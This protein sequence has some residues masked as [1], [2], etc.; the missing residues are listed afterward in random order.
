MCGICGVYNFDKEKVIDGQLLKRMNNIMAH[1]GP[2]DEGYYVNQNVGFGHRRL[3]I[4]DLSHAGHQPMPNEDGSIWIT[5]NGEIYNY[6]ELREELIKKGHQFKSRTDTEV[7]VHLYEE[8][9]EECV[10]RLNGM[11]TFAI[12]DER[13]R[14]LFIARDH[15]GIKPLYYTVVNNKLLFASEI[16]AILEH[17]GFKRCVNFEAVKDYFTFQNLFGDKTFFEGIK[18]L[19]PGC[20]LTCHN[21]DCKIRQYWDVFFIEDEN[22]GEQFYIEAFLEIFEDSVKREMLTSDVPV[23]TYLSGGIDSGSITTIASKVI[24]GKVKSFT[25]GFEEKTGFDE[26]EYAEMIAEIAGTEHHQFVPT[27]EDFIEIFPDLVWHLDEPRVGSSYPPYFVAQLA[28]RYV[29]V[30]LAGQGGDE[31][32]A[33]Y[34]RHL[35][36]SLAKDEEGFEKECYQL[37]NCLFLEE[38]R[39]H[40][41]SK[42]IIEQVNDYSTF[43]TLKTLYLDKTNAKHFLNKMLYLEIKT[44]LHGL[45]IVEDKISMAHSLETRVPFLD[46]RL[47]EFAARIPPELKIKNKILKY[48]PRIA[49]KKL[50]PP[51]ITERPKMGFGCSDAIWWRGAMKELVYELLLGDR[52]KSRG[53]FNYDFV[54]SIVNRHMNGERNYSVRI[55]SLL[56]FELWHR[57]FMDRAGF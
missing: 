1:R 37:H 41:F 52:A 26:S 55:W 33:G 39:P 34:H 7:I 8:M 27:V 56:N 38:I 25:C 14:K 5:Y 16:K 17:P 57:I 29:K 24:G 47:V 13:N 45:L 50:L 21:G 46:I 9:G 10:N 2:D 49:M 28:S 3:S 42:E 11:F 40:L 12:W 22:R 44:Y 18:I 32:F 43:Q 6:P 30:I 20:T 15:M 36:G 51:I 31:L 53:Y 19:L 54:K 23:A 35:M 48:L 4:I